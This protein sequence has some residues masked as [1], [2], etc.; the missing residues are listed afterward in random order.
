M[1]NEAATIGD[2]PA[3]ISAQAAFH[4]VNGG[5]Y[6][7]AITCLNVVAPGTCIP[8]YPTNAPTFLDSSVASL[9][10]KSGY[11]RS[12]GPG[13]TPVPLNTLVSGTLSAASYVYLATPVSQGQQGVRGFGRIQRRPLLHAVGRCAGRDPSSLALDTTTCNILSESRDATVRSQGPRRV[14]FSP[15]PSRSRG[16]SGWPDRTSSPIR[17]PCSR[18]R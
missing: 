17:R 9:V 3:V 13:A 10:A 8:S 18:S 6:T 7:G 16:A 12:F 4:S 11:A 15:A 14:T 1:A 5:W 2:I